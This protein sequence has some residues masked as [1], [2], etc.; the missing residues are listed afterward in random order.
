MFLGRVE[1]GTFSVGRKG[2]YAP[3][4]VDPSDPGV[5]Y[6]SVVDNKDNPSI[7]VVFNTDRA[8][9]EYCITFSDGS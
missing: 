4:P 7:F 2:I 6:H 3:P 9:P 1:T 5:L 8:Y